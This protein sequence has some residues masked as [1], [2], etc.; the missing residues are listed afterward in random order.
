MARRR[1]AVV[2][3]VPQPLATEID[4]IRR[5]L[6]DHYLGHV[7]PHITLVPPVNVRADELD[8]VLA[9]VRSAA[10]AA[11]PFSFRLG[12][13][14]S[15]APVTPVAYLEVQG[16]PRD[17]ERLHALE[18]AMRAGPFDRPRDHPFVPHC[19]VA[20]ELTEGRLAPAIDLLA[21]FSMPASFERVHVLEE[22]EPGRVWRPIADAPFDAPAG[23]VGEGGLALT[24][25]VSERAEPIDATAFTI[26]ARRDGEPVA[27]A[28]GWVGADGAELAELTVAD[29]H[30]R[31]G[32]GRQLLLAVEHE[33]RRR[34]ASRI[35]GWT[36]S[37]AAGALLAGA[38]W[39]PDGD[40]R[41]VRVLSL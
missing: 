30:R 18:Q 31:T 33:A 28:W 41:W 24:L 36:R 27:S 19:T 8:A 12:P 38:G 7:D 17:L 35:G 14:A 11:G 22:Q 23:R 39:A 26:T 4:G 34:G 5:A 20:G 37:A 6:G 16:A 1:L 15:F 9:S 10:A 32:I 2:L 29:A 25:E 3:L 40:G 21:N 13:V